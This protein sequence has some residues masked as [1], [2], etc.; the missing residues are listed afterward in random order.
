MIMPVDSDLKSFESIMGSEFQQRFGIPNR[1][2]RLWLQVY[3]CTG[4]N[5]LLWTKSLALFVSRV[6]NGSHVFA[7]LL[8]LV[9][10][11]MHHRIKP[12]LWVCPN[13]KSK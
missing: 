6:G 9:D 5:I 4:V 10:K 1:A 13:R 3:S 7:V 11:Q 8:Y 12:L 2:L